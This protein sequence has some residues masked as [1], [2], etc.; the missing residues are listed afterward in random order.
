M[1]PP[2]IAV[3][4]SFIAFAAYCVKM[5]LTAVAAFSYPPPMPKQEKD[6]AVL[7]VRDAPREL[8]HKLKAA[9][10]LQGMSL[11]AYL[12]AMM[13]N[14]VSELERKGMLPKGK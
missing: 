4:A 7:Y 6:S 9:A 12:L 3:F 8:A 10:A 5:L 14:H 2:S 13:Q 11:Q 1:V